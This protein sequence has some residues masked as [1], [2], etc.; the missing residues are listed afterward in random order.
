MKEIIDLGDTKY[1]YYNAC[2]GT[3]GFVS[4]QLYFDG[5]VEATKQLC[6]V[7]LTKDRFLADSLIYPIIFSAR[8]SIELAI[9]IAFNKCLLINKDIRKKPLNGHNIEWLYNILKEYSV[10]NIHL[11]KALNE[12]ENSIPNTILQII[13]IDTS[14]ETFRYRTDTNKNN[15][16]DGI[17]RH[18]NIRNIYIEYSEFCERIDDFLFSLDNY[19]ECIE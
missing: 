4:N 2:V 11:L 8:H 3:N 1:W 15:H 19:L 17:L 6:V 16:L 13:K 7:V 9:K 12:I 14:G 10:F 18:I 5:F